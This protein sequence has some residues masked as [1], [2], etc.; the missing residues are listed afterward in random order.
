MGNPHR[1]GVS[2]AEYIGYGGERGELKHLSILRKEINRDSG[3]SGERT[4]RSLALM[5][6]TLAERSWK[7][8]L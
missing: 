5:V 1:K 2:V 3:S 7:G 4:R 8:L 6:R